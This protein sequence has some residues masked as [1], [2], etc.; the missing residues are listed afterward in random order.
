[1]R[2]AKKEKDAKARK[3]KAAQGKIA[4]K[5]DETKRKAEAA[6]AGEGPEPSNTAEAG[7]RQEEEEQKAEKRHREQAE[8]AGS[9]EEGTDSEEEDKKLP[10]EVA[11]ILNKG[12]GI[13][14]GGLHPGPARAVLVAPEDCPEPGEM[15]NLV[16]ITEDFGNLLVTLEGK[17]ITSEVLS[18]FEGGHR[19]DRQGAGPVRRSGSGAAQDLRERRYESGDLVGCSAL[20]GVSASAG[21]RANFGQEHQRHPAGAVQCVA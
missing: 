1:L 15:R 20:R 3:E 2:K 6:A 7:E 19:A 10:W 9:L 18:T 17:R 5:S 4:A 16:L 11:W 21:L 14:P 13:T 12:A 8:E